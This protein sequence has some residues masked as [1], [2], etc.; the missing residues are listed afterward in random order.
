MKLCVTGG[1][2]YIGSVVAQALV[3]AGNEVGVIDNL[4][5]G[6]R[7][8]IPRDAVSSRATSVM[9]TRSTARSGRAPRPS[10]TSPR[11]AWWPIR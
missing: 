8:A 11:S 7:A 5:T 10:S 1:A 3:D 9:A 2:G 4:S 6:H